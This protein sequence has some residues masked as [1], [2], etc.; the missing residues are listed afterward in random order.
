MRSLIG[1][2]AAIVLSGCVGTMLPGRMYASPSG[3]ILQFEIETSYGQGK[4][5]AFNDQTG[6]KFTGEY[7]AI[8]RG[9]G[10]ML[11]NAGNSN[12]TLLQPPLSANGQ[13]VLVG[14]KGT[15]IRLYLEIKPGLRPTGHGTGTDE[16]G[17]RYEVFF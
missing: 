9:G 16:E 10:M 15:M 1:V 7:S 2:F 8:R 11:G 3:Q 5:T 13:G 17:R 6:E 14:D 4:M 12:V